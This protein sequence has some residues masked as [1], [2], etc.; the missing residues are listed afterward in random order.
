MS[1]IDNVL[2]YLGQPY[3]I[4]SIDLEPVIYRR[5][6]NFEFE[7]SGLHKHSLNCTLYVWMA[8]PHRELMGIYKGIKSVEDLKDL[9]GYCSVKY[10]NL[11]S[12]IQI[13][14]EDQI[15]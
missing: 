13:E 12:R 14:R 9:L 6:N 15:E 2:R 7:I 10:Q 1:Q 11:L 8:F 4:K 5:L 3:C